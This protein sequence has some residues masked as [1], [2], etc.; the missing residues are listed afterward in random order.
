MMLYLQVNTS[1][2]SVTEL[3][4]YHVRRGASLM[5]LILRTVCGWM[6][7]LL[8]WYLCLFQN[9]M[10]TLGQDSVFSMTVASTLTISLLNSG[11][12]IRVNSSAPTSST[13]SIRICS[14]HSASIWFSIMIRSSSVTFH[15]CPAKCTTAKSRPKSRWWI[16]WFTVLITSA[17]RLRCSSSVIR[18]WSGHGGLESDV[19]G[20][21]PP[22]TELCAR[23]LTGRRKHCFWNSLLHVLHKLTPLLSAILTGVS[24]QFAC[25]TL[26]RNHAHASNYSPV[27]SFFLPLFP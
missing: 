20:I 21:N 17:C 15:W 3:S 19:W 9:L 14:P 7:I 18:I 8:R 2:P 26:Y 11:L 1:R 10:W 6:M 27:I 25:A 13:F 5:V 24:L 12:P 4:L 22:L 16:F 23:P